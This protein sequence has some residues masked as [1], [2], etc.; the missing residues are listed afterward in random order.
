MAKFLGAAFGLLALGIV[1]SFLFSW[2]VMWLWN[3]CLIGA[4]DGVHEVTWLQAWG[5]S[6]LFGVLFQGHTTSSS[7]K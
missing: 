4:I 5:I 6:V 2:P 7:S 1:L 3:N